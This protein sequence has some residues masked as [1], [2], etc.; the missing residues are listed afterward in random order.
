MTTV[1]QNVF[2]RRSTDF[3]RTLGLR[4]HIGGYIPLMPNI[5]RALRRTIRPIWI[6]GLGAAAWSN[7]FKVQEA[8]GLK[9]A[10]QRPD[11][12]AVSVRSTTTTW[13]QQLRRRPRSTTVHEP[14]T[15]VPADMT[16]PVIDPAVNVATPRT[17]SSPVTNEG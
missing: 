3:L 2:A 16:E 6:A 15:A 4:R 1:I 13:T 7:R 10:G 12:D 8:L 9:P 17:D 5:G 14:S 11:S